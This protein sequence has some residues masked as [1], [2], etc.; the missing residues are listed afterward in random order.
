MPCIFHIHRLEHFMWSSY[1]CVSLRHISRVHDAVTDIARSKGSRIPS[2][3][4]GTCRSEYP[5]S[6]LFALHLQ[7]MLFLSW[8]VPYPPA[9]AVVMSSWWAIPAD[10]YKSLT[11]LINYQIAR[12][13]FRL[14]IWEHEYEQRV[15]VP[16]MVSF[17]VLCFSL[18]SFVWCRFFL[19]WEQLSVNK[20][21][22]CACWVGVYGHQEVIQLFY[23]FS[24]HCEPSFH[25]CQIYSTAEVQYYLSRTRVTE[26]LL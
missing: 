14:P 9:S 11:A 1:P 21:T 8:R 17:Y 20:K 12:G 22:P 16:Y 18:P 19:H 7:G 26:C 3:R 15:L 23:S 4:S 10:S 5:V 13:L 6:S 24:T 2:L 25:N